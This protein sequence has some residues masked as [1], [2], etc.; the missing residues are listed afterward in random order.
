MRIADLTTGETQ[1]RDAFE[2]LQRTWSD[3]KPQ[4]RDDNSRNLE[5]NHLQP[6]AREVAAAYPVIHELA[7][8]LAQAER[9]CRPWE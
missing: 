2:Q 1:L 4:W 5:E 7:V 8:V 3:T 9:D 6:L